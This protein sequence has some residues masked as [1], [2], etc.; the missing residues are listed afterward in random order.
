[1]LANQKVISA[2]TD[3]IKYAK[4]PFN[5]QTINQ[6]ALRRLLVTVMDPKLAAGL[7]ISQLRDSFL[8]NTGVLPIKKN[9]ETKQKDPSEF[10]EALLHSVGL[11]S[12][13]QQ[14]QANAL[15]PKIQ[16]LQDLMTH[17]HFTFKP[18]PSFSMLCIALPRTMRGAVISSHPIEV[19]SFEVE[20]V[21]Y[22]PTA[23]VRGTK[24]HFTALVDHNGTVVEYD[25]LPSEK[26]KGHEYCSTTIPTVER[27]ETNA[28]DI[29]LVFCVRKDVH[30]APRR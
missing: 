26:A 14:L 22:C 21:T 8:G 16:D 13:I 7:T 2:L 27:K 19:T 17:E 23:A 4:D 5:T 15:N 18:N 1:M 25:D 20:G 29:V 12:Q 28:N 9:L 3:K 10:L 24:G 6:K 30:A 11:N